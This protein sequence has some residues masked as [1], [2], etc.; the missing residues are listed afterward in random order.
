MN[1]DSVLRELDRARLCLSNLLK[2]K[3]FNELLIKNAIIHIS[4]AIN[5]VV[6]V[7]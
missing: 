5:D 3:T 4:N 7:D 6:D 2:E 1:T